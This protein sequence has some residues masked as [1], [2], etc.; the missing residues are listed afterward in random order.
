MWKVIRN[1]VL[2]I[3]DGFII[4]RALMREEDAEEI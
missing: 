1:A 4:V 2:F 3:R